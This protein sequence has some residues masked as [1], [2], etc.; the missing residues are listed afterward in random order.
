MGNDCA[1][2]V[3]GFIVWDLDLSLSCLSRADDADLDRNIF[4]PNALC[5]L[6]RGAERPARAFHIHIR[7]CC[8]DGCPTH[9]PLGFLP[10]S[11]LGSAD[12]WTN[13]LYLFSP[14][15]DVEPLRH[16]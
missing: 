7:N 6:A 11:L 8:F 2:A 12:R 9:L 5:L 1:L 4:S 15:S 10:G 3:I 16:S 13:V 14:G